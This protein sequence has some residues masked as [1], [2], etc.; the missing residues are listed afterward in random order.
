MAALPVS[1][2]VATRMQ[3]VSL[4]AGLPQG[5]GQKLGQHL[6]RHVLE[7]GGGAVPQLQAV[8]GHRPPSAPA[9]PRRSRRTSPGRRRSRPK[10]QQLLLGIVRQVQGHDLGRPL[11]RIHGHSARLSKKARSICG[12]RSWGQQTAVP[13]QAHLDGLRRSTSGQRSCPA[14]CNTSCRSPPS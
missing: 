9:R 10:V 2:E 13:A 5:G 4:L 14:C 3:A 11:L 6:Q 1:P 8:G 12:I 7:G